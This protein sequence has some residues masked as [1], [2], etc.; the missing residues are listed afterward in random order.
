MTTISLINA[1]VIDG[2]GADPFTATIDI[3]DERI[4]AVRR[5]AARPVRGRVPASG[6]DVADTTVIDCAGRTVMPGLTEAHCHI[7]FNNIVSME[8]VVAIQPEDHALISLRNAQMLM[9]RGFTSLYSAAAAKP[10]L[11]VA[12]R[13][14]IAER[15]VRRAAHPRRQPGDLALGQ[16]RRH[17]QQLSPAAAQPRLRDHRRRRGRI[18]Q[19]G[20]ACRP[21]RRRQPQ[22]QRLRRPRLGPHARRRHDDG[23]QPR[24]RSRRWSRWRARAGSWSRPIARA[25]KGVKMC[26][27][28]GVQVD[29]PR[30]PCRRGGARHAGGGARPRLRR[31][32]ARPAA[33]HAARGR[34]LRHQVAGV[35]LCEPRTGTGDDAGLH[36]RPPQARRPRPARR[37]LRRLRHQPDGHQRPRPRTLRRFPRLLADGGAG[38]GDEITAAN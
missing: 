32:G 8:A 20:A 10:R 38:R 21:R 14:A 4:V 15:A 36:A 17:R 16:P 26:V 19:G 31:A 9:E 27:R 25:P 37:R 3:V 6:P 5:D 33:D 1:T 13:N 7:S 28:H 29:L 24:T 2:S 22:D 35:A 34:R 30:G 12:V 11:D 18:H 23:D